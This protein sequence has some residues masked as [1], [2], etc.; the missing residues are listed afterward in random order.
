VR[1]GRPRSQEQRLRFAN[2]GWDLARRLPPTNPV[3]TLFDRREP[4]FD[5]RLELG[6]GKN[7]GPIP[8]DAFTHEFADVIWI[9]SS[10]DALNH[11]L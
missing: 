2:L 7:V 5:E 9:Y 4:C 8:L 1:A 10:F 11:H 3:E 6:V